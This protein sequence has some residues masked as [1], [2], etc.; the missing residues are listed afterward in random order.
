MTRLG[1]EYDRRSFEE[2]V[3]NEALSSRLAAVLTERLCLAADPAREARVMVAELKSLGHQLYSWDESDDFQIWGDDYVRP[4]PN[5]IIVELRYPEGEPAS[6]RVTFGP[7]PAGVPNPR[8]Q[9][10]GTPMTFS[11]LRVEAIGHGHVGS[12]DVSVELFVGSNDKRILKAG[13]R[14]ADYQARAFWCE[15]C[16]GL[17]IP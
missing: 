16:R 12:L 6:G 14:S 17:W 7:W 13:Q 11:S 9:Q 4:G 5:R 3:P 2:A 1:Q 15:S 8:C 10:C